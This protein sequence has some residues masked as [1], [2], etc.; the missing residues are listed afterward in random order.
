M[1]GNTSFWVQVLQRLTCRVL[2]RCQC[3]DK[4]IRVPFHG[5]GS[6]GQGACQFRNQGAHGTE[7]GGHQAQLSLCSVRRGEASI[8]GG[9][10][11]PAG[12]LEA[13]HVGGWTRGACACTDTQ[14]GK[15]KSTHGCLP[16]LGHGVQRMQPGL[17]PKCLP[18]RHLS[19]AAE[20]AQLPRRAGS[21]DMLGGRKHSK[22]RMSCHGLYTRQLQPKSAIREWLHKYEDKTQKLQLNGVCCWGQ[23]APIYSR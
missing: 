3:V 23:T 9:S 2:G 10:C 19:G 18:G 12:C 14:Q 5:A 17:A 8:I 1:C 21:G 15:E 20:P 7:A 4:V 11:C 16:L 13:R 6:R 22:H